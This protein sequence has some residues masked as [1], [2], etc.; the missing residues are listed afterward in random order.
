[1]TRPRDVFVHPWALCESESVGA[2]TKI[3]AFSHV[4]NGARVGA[5]C[6][7]CDHVFIETGAI[8]G[9]RVTVKNAV[10]LWDKVILED[11]VFV[12]PNAVFTNDRVPRARSPRKRAVF[13]PTVV[14]RV[15]TIGANATI[16]CGV[17]VGELAFVGAG[18]V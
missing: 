2:G 4:M 1:M 5:G 17:R 11:D 18:A 6:N 15:A 9:D 12:G 3:W 8:V 7:I 14:C 13:L 16:V 10:L